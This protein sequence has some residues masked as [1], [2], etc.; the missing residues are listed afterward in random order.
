MC[1]TIQV[2]TRVVAVAHFPVNPARRVEVA[3]RMR[4]MVATA[5]PVLNPAKMLVAVA[6]VWRET[7]GRRA[8]LVVRMCVAVPMPW[9]AT[10]LGPMRVVAVPFW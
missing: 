9:R 2:R 10:I 1:A 6:R 3:A 7:Q 4:A 8:A 5:L